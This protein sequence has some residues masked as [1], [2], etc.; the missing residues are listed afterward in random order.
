MLENEIYIGNMVQGKYGSVSYKTKQNRPRPREQWYRVEGTHEPIIERALWEKVQA[1]R[2]QR[3]RPF[4]EGTVGLFSQKARC[5]YCGYAMRSSKSRGKHYLKCPNRHVAKDACV[6]SFISVARLEEIAAAEL[7]R[8]NAEYLDQDELARRLEYSGNLEQKKTRLAADVTA[9]EKK[10]EE[11]RRG[12]RGLYLD[13]V[14][15]ILSE[16]DYAELS[17]DLSAECDRLERS[18]AEGRKKVEELEA[19]AE[20]DGGC[21][22]RAGRYMKSG[23]LS[24]EIVEAMIDHIYVGKRIPGTKNVPVEI[25]WDF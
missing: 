2:E 25:H 14:K 4:A 16:G 23:R 5:M 8:M 22:E 24:R 11:C 6:G 1:L 13:K 9:C 10:L 12:L 19:Q 3:V 21:R 7:N 15:G 18:A 20:T 17:K